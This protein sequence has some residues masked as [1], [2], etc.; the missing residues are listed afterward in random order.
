MSPFSTAVNAAMRRLAAEPRTVFVGQSVRYDG[1][2]IYHS[3][4]GVPLAQR[5]EMPVLEDFQLGFCTGLALTGYVPICIFPRCDFLLLA[6]NQLVNHLDKLP[7]FG[8]EPKVI[9]RT[10][11]G[12]RAPLDAGPQHTQNHADA[13]ERMLRTVRVMEVTTAE[14]VERA[15]AQAWHDKGSALIVEA[16]R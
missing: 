6:A 14:D 13:F 8:W 15:Y 11:V 2:A 1:A 10:V 16:P 7:Y 12:A 5:R 9:I 4:D 3:L